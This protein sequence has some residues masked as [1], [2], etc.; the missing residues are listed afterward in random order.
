MAEAREFAWLFYNYKVRQDPTC[1]HLVDF[2]LKMVQEVTGQN[3][4]VEFVFPEN[5]QARESVANLLVKNSLERGNFAVLVPGSAR[6]NKCWPTGRFAQL[7]DHITEKY[8][9]P[10]AAIG[11]KG[12]SQLT[13]GIKDAAK[14]RVVDLAGQTNI[15]ELCELMKSAR[16]VVSNDTGPGHIAAAMGVPTVLIFGP[17]NPARVSP[18]GRLDRVVAFDAQNRGFKADSYDPRHEIERITLDMVV[19]KVNNVMS[20]AE[21]RQL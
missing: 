19:Q 6:A 10:V 7:A 5:K 14:T 13:A 17:T 21:Y 3:S 11:T 16:L 8:A 18:Y 2:Y 9:M 4:G 12:E 20:T 15:P 1:I